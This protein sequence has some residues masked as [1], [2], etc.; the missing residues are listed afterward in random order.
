MS[1]ELGQ[2]PQSTALAEAETDSIAELL[3]RDPMNYQA[4]DRPRLIAALRA[5]RERFAKAEAEGAG[6]KKKAPPGA[7]TKVSAL[8]ARK[9]AASL[10]DLGL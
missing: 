5:Q 8:L 7:A 9:T 2:L 10:D 1:E 3:S 4:Q 6:T